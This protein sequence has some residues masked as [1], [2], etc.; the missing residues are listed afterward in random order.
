MHV[1]V[2]AFLHSGSS[3]LNDLDDDYIVGAA[4]AKCGVEGDDLARSVLG[5]N[6]ITLGHR[7]TEHFDD[8]R[9]DGV[10]EDLQLHALLLPSMTSIRASVI[11]LVP[12]VNTGLEQRLWR[13]GCHVMIL[14]P[15]HGQSGIDHLAGDGHLAAAVAQDCDEQGDDDD[16]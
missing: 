15:V 8:G 6:V 9:V 12:S 11:G 1:W 14:Q 16:L 5:D 3:G 4:F 10:G 13:A 7:G 2:I